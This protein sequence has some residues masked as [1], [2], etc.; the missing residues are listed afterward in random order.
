MNS[1]APMVYADGLLYVPT[2]KRLT[3]IDLRDGRVVWD[4]TRLKSVR[5]PVKLTD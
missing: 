3:A 4:R 1:Y 2:D 5:C